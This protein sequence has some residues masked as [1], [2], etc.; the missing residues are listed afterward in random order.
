MAPLN[1][2]TIVSGFL[3]SPI[4]FYGFNLYTLCS[5]SPIKHPLLL[6]L[7]SPDSQPSP[8]NTL[9]PSTHSP[10]RYH[11]HPLSLLLHLNMQN[12]CVNGSHPRISNYTPMLA[13][14]KVKPVLESL[15]PLQKAPL[16]SRRVLVHRLITMVSYG[17]LD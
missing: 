14:G 6:I 2:L 12:I 15:P 1:Q 4:I 3:F 13:I 10:P 8:K 16:D 9:R 5:P 17:P 7:S 11:R